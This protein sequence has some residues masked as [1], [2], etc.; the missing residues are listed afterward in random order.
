MGLS[1]FP[2]PAEG[3]LTVLVNTVN[4]MALLKNMVRSV[5]QIVGAAAGSGASS[6]VEEPTAEA[7]SW[8]RE[9]RV[10]ITR[11]GSLCGGGIERVWPAM[12]CSVCLCRFEEEE[13]V[14]ELACKHY[15]HKGCLEKWFDNHYRT[16]PLCR[17]IS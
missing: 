5:L 16:C 2:S 1:N 10:S 17:S 7:D 9:R 14:G 15:F 3:V 13:E 11:F 8:R 12:E 6:N 4:T